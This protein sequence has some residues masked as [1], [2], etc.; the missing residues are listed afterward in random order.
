MPS[1]WTSRKS[2][3]PPVRFLPNSTISPSGPTTTQASRGLSNEI[4]QVRAKIAKAQ[5]AQR[6]SEILFSSLLPLR[7]CDLCAHPQMTHQSTSVH[8]TEQI[9]SDLARTLKG[10]ET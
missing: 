4:T 6:I 8:Q 9:A 3:K 2:K 5:R 10:G 1:V 7:L